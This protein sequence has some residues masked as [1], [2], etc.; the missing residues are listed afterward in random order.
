MKSTLKGLVIIAVMAMLVFTVASCDSD[1]G[2]DLPGNNPGNGL[3]NAGL[4]G[5]WY[6]REPSDPQ[7]NYAMLKFS[8]KNLTVGTMLG[9]VYFQYPGTFTQTETNINYTISGYGSGT[10][11]YTP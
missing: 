10:T 11:R 7:R 1:S 2:S 3:S 9:G 6:L 4:E 8:G 5:S